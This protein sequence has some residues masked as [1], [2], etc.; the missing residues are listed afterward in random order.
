MKY[1]EKSSTETHSVGYEYDNINN[2]TQLV[3]TIGTVERKTSY[4][5]DDDNRPVSVTTEDG[6]RSYTYDDWGRVATLTTK[7]GN[8][9]VTVQTY[10]YK[11]NANGAPTNQI[12]AVTVRDGNGN[13]RYAYTYTYDQ[14]GNI[15]DINNGTYTTSYAYDSANQL[16]REDNQEANT[17]TVWT[18]D[19][20]G[21]ILTR[22]STPTPPE[23]WV[24]ERKPT[25][26]I[27]TPMGRPA[28]I[29]QQK[30]HRL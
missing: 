24:R 14:N 12:S 11:S 26:C 4:T 16:I 7:H 30:T 2:L 8:N 15:T 19:N 29:L 6:S 28:E 21:N 18:Y 27:P 5:Y 9:T 17:T 25:I 13:Q 22:T 10:T 3:E 20:A 23:Q 1:V